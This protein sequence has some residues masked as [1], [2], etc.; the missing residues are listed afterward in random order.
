[1][2][3]DD[4]LIE[5][6]NNQDFITGDKIKNLVEEFSDAKYYKIDFLRKDGKW[7][8]EN[9]KKP[10]FTDFYGKNIFLGHSDIPFNR[11]LYLRLRLL[12]VRKVFT[13]NLLVNKKNH[14]L[15]PVGLTNWTTESIQHQITGNP[16]I[17]K[18]ILHLP[19][20]IN[21][22]PYSIYSNFSQ[23]TFPRVRIP[24][25]RLVRNIDIVRFGNEEVTSQNR[26]TYLSEI[27]S[28][29]MVLCPRGNGLDTH[30]FWETLY[31]GSVP[32][33]VAKDLPKGFLSDFDLPMIVIRDWNEIT[34]IKRIYS[35][36]EKC[37]STSHVSD[38][39]T[40]SFIKKY[41]LERV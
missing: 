41:I 6:A 31:L 38:Y 39:L 14:F 37:L 8:G 12:G 17:F 19:K 28:S 3:S 25:S 11:E 35:N 9:I 23:H 24:L 10:K 36:Y 1:M 5:V 13:T 26:L 4:F 29:D 7:R 22:I 34:D 33:V 30:R 2:Y 18:E 32:I 16:S 27:R 40:F 15:L 20:S 21:R